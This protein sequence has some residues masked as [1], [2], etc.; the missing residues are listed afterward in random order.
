MPNEPSV[1]QLDNWPVAGHEWA[2]RLLQQ[3]LPASAQSTTRL[4]HAYL[5]LG[6]RQIGKSTLARA[7]AGAL[8]CTG[9]NARPCGRCRACR[10]MAEGNHPDFRLIQPLDRDGHVD[11]DDGILRADQAGDIIRDVATRPLE[12][13][14]K[15]FVV[16]DVHR[17]NDSFGNKLLKTLEEPPAHT[18]LCLTATD[19]SSLLPTIVSRCQILDLRPLDPQTIAAALSA[20]WNVADAEAQVLARLSGGRLGWAVQQVQRPEDAAQRTELLDSLMRLVREDRVSR[21]AY[22]EA[23]AR[24]RDNRTMFAL[25]E[26]WATWWRDVLLVQSGCAEAC[27][28]IDRLEDLTGLARQVSA[29]AVQR[30]L[31]TLKR[32]EGYLHHTVNTRLALDVLL[33][34]MPMPSRTAP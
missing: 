16:Q 3:A 14:Y 22:A 15:F 34:Q 12:S 11:R 4:S 24:N 29:H 21:L 28:N 33:L 1:S 30:Y 2:V 32:I 13:S 27:S 26:L 8:L 9:Q 6:P 17:A 7:L 19:R 5:F 23:L 10:L 25:L 31:R 20:G 18:I